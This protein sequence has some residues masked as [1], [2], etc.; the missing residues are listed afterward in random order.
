MPPLKRRA[1][2]KTLAHDL[3]A[4]VAARMTASAWAK[5]EMHHW[6]GNV[7]ELRNV[8]TRAGIEN[9]S[10]PISAEYI[11]FDKTCPTASDN[12]V[13]SEPT[14]KGVRVDPLRQTIRRHVNQALKLYDGNIRATARASV[15][16]RQQCTSTFRWS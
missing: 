3:S 2:L 6:P 13:D 1:D 8:L 16:V 15:L 14:A 10:C 4:N 9:R 5:L 7:R 11:A 12:Q